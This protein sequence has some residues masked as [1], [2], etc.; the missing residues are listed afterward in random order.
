MRWP[1]RRFVTGLTGGA[2]VTV[3]E[4]IT[5]LQALPQDAVVKVK[6][7]V[8]CIDARYCDAQPPELSEEGDVYIN[9]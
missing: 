2:A 9:D 1:H 6:E 7:W 8:Y 3:A 5:L 4:Y